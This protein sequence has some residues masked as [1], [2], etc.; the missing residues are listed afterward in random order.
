MDN[1]PED[2]PQGTLIFIETGIHTNAASAIWTQQTFE[3]GTRISTR[4]ITTAVESMELRVEL[5]DI[6]VGPRFAVY[7]RTPFLLLNNDDNSWWELREDLH[8]GELWWYKNTELQS[9]WGSGKLV[10]RKDSIGGV[11]QAVTQPHSRGDENPKSQAG[12]LMGNGVYI[13]A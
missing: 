10:V 11:L 9:E 12:I 8:S 2:D 3:L 13:E 4:I 7:D 1:Y 5:G 6:R